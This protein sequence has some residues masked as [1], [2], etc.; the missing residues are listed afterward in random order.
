MWI[1]WEA[2]TRGR[3]NREAKVKLGKINGR[4][5]E[6]KMMMDTCGAWM[7]IMDGVGA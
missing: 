6:R 2:E 5:K 3:E 1:E 4:G 7:M